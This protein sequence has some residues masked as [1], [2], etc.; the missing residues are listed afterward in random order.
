M[1]EN[2][3]VTLPELV[4]RRTIGGIVAVWIAAGIIGIAVGVFADSAWR[5]PWLVVGMGGCVIL[6]FA[7]QLAYG[8]SQ[9]FTERVATSALGALFVLGVISLGFGLATIVPS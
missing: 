3:G 8:R 2:S 7:I 1:G 6:A 9:G 5:A 4:P